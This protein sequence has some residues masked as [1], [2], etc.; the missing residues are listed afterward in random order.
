MFGQDEDG[1]CVGVREATILLGD[2]AEQAR[3][4]ELLLAEAGGDAHG[5]V[6]R[7]LPVRVG[8]DPRELGLAVGELPLAGARRSALVRSALAAC[9]SG[10]GQI[11]T[12]RA[13]AAVLRTAREEKAAGLRGSGCDPPGM[14]RRV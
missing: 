6:G 13:L 1:W 14:G 9:A 7:A 2:V 8:D 5:D 4:I 10:A 3:D 12:P 11:V